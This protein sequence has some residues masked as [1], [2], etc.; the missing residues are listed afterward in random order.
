MRIPVE[1]QKG[2]KPV[3]VRFIGDNMQILDD[4]IYEVA[5]RTFVSETSCKCVATSPK[6]GPEQVASAAK[7]VVDKSAIDLHSIADLS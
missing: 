7:V 6:R 1:R 5:A 4:A 2:N 3:A